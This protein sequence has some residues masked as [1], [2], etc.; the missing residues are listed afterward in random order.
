MLVLGF[1]GGDGDGDVVCKVVH[2]QVCLKLYVGATGL[3]V[4][5]LLEVVVVAVCKLG[6]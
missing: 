3:V 4:R 5:S 1:G 6:C 2:E